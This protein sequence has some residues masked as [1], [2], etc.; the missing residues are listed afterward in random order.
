VVARSS[1]GRAARGL[2]VGGAHGTRRVLDRAH[3]LAR[4]DARVTPGRFS[5]A[6]HVRSLL[7]VYDAADL[8]RLDLPW[9][10]YPAIQAVEE[11]LS[12]L[13]GRARVFE[14]GAGASTLWLRAR[15]A[16][17]ISVEHDADF[18]PVVESLV[19][20]APGS[21]VVLSRRLG[22]GDT[23]T[24]GGYVSAIEETEGRFDLIVVDGRERVRCVRAALPRLTD[25]GI[26]LLD[27]SQR[28]RYRPVLEDEGL[29][30]VE[31]SG[32]VPSLPLPR[33]TA[34]LRR[35]R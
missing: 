22:G 5:V 15:A 27:D 33:R 12:A 32:L 21:G 34:L 8:A 6:T 26:I 14:Y 9:W 2:Y 23:G 16:E 7:S 30:V 1:Y 29:D 4:L 17:V 35:A 11:H 19:A 25:G 31:Y 24:S 13:G 18:M 3:L 20:D 28:R 10:T